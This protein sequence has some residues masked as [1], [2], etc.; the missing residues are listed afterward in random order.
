MATKYTLKELMSEDFPNKT[1]MRRMGY[2]ANM[3]E[4]K[5][6]FRLINEEVFYNKLSMPKIVLK[7]RLR[8]CWGICQGADK[9]FR[10]G[11]SRCTI[12][13][14]ERWYCKQWLIMSLAHEMVHQYQWDI[15]SEI[16]C[17]QGKESLMSHGPSFYIFRK[18]LAKHGIPLR[19][20][21][22]HHKWLSSK[23]PSMAL[24]FRS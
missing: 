21:N 15:Y 18:R 11:K 6:L 5:S 13:L 19:E 20:F 12:V 4:V 24:L 14:A 10:K 9:P 7:S 2:I 23:E 1:Y 17:R 16:R 8:D 22:D 3:R